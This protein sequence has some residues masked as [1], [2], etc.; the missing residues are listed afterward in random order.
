M[1]FWS[2]LL[3]IPKSHFTK[4]YARKNFD[5][6]KIGKMKYGLL[7]IRYYDKKLLDLVRLWISEHVASLG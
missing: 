1:N 6:T 7:H 3:R 2:K 4:P 5:P